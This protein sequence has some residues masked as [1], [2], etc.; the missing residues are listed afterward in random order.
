[1]SMDLG[2][3]SVQLNGDVAVTGFGMSV[4]LS[5]ATAVYAWTEVDDSV[6]TTWTD[7]DDSATMTWRD[8][9]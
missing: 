4:S 7:V 2:N 8:A 6:T 3:I 5:D 1:M 9:A